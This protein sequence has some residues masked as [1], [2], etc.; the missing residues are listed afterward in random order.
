MCKNSTLSRIGTNLPN[1][2]ESL[3]NILQKQQELNYSVARI[4]YIE[5]FVQD[6]CWICTKPTHQVIQ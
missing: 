1:H 5:V 4:I 2:H 6:L 3:D